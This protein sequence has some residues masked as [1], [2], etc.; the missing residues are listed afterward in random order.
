MPEHFCKDCGASY[1]QC[2]CP[3]NPLDGPTR[4]A[5]A[6]ASAR[7]EGRR[8]GLEEAVRVIE[9]LTRY[10]VQ[11]LEVAAGE[12]GEHPE[13]E[14]IDRDEALSALRA[15]TRTPG[16]NRHPGQQED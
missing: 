12:I 8:E 11:S 3:G 10:E 6:L 9:G 14:Y 1:D 13:G 15:L 7:E 16:R 2:P 5:A 4:H